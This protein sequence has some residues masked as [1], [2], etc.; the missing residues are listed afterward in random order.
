MEKCEEKNT[1]EEIKLKSFINE[2]LSYYDIIFYVF[3]EYTFLLWVAIKI[4][5]FFGAKK[6]ENLKF[7]RQ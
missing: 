5:F 3:P 7:S 6:N 1:A 4:L 2:F